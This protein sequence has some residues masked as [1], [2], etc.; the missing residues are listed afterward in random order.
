MAQLAVD[1]TCSRTVSI[2]GTRVM[3]VED[4][5]FLTTGGVYV[6]DLRDPRLEGAG[7]VTYVRA[8][9]AHARVTVDAS[10]A[11]ALDGVLAVFTAADLTDLPPPPPPLGFIPPALARPWLA[12]GVVRYVG[13]PIAAIVTESRYAGEDVAEL[14]SVDYEPLTAVVDPRVSARDE[15]LLFP[16][17]GSNTALAFE[18]GSLD[19]LFDDCEVVV[20]Q[21]MTN[22]RVAPVPLEVRGTACVWEGERLTLWAS[23]QSP[24][25]ARDQIATALSLPPEQVHFIAPDVGGGF[26]AKFGVSIEDLLLAVLSRRLGRPMR[27]TETR[28]ENMLGMGHGRAQLQTVTIGGTRD[29][30]ITAYSLDVLQDSGAYPHFGAV[31]PFMTQLMATGTY[32]IARVAVRTKSVVTNTAPVVAYRGAGRPEATAAI[33]RAVDLFAAEIGMDPAEVRRRNLFD[34]DAFPLTT[35]VGAAYDSGD[36]AGAL[37]A[38]LAAATYDELRAEQRRRRESGEVKL[39]GIGVSN[40]VEI[41]A[42]PEAG[43][44]FARINVKPDGSVIVYTGTSPHGQGHATSFAMLAADELGVPL[45]RITVVHGDT[46]LVARGGG[47]GGSRSLQLGGAA[48]HQG[49]IETVDRARELAGDLFEAAAG[50]I[51]LDKARGGFHVA[52]SPD[53]VRSWAE[54]ATSADADAGLIVDTDFTAQGATFPF[55]AHVAVVEVDAETGKVELLSMTTVDDAGPVINPVV[56]EGQ[57]HGGIA[58][59]VA[60]ALFE[61]VLYDEDGNPQSTNL[62]DYAFPT[63]AELPDFT[64]VDMATPS[65]LNPLGVKGIGEAG[66][67]GATPAV[68]NAV[69]DAVAHLGVR[70]I[71][72]P[73]TAERVWRAIQEGAK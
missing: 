35:Q 26:G 3:R 21:Q 28:T 6:D 1:A 69:V 9:M 73:T 62:A 14:V 43:T 27:W 48:V 60:Q 33:E 30:R 20:T 61:E 39:L 67:I 47:T 49:A 41:T 8:V 53:D 72:M 12:N 65:P 71:E 10:A 5:K 45:D 16:D 52:G 42:G 57:R 70:H 44:E 38:V 31:L 29:G 24:H 34:K 17:H 46:D 13:E 66:T 37:E 55:G 56:V 22:Q 2:L 50:D 64:L 36:Y 68:Q 25:G 18:A 32:D 51:V 58:Q 15:T 54:V 63:A 7:H 59:G 23:T 40:Y 19:G 4:P 11:A